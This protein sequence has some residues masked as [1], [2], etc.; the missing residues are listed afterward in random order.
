[1]P[2]SRTVRSEVLDFEPYSPG[3][4]IPEI[5]K[6]HNLARVIKLA[7]NENPLGTSPLVQR[8]IERL[9]GYAFR[10]PSPGC[11]ELTEALAEHLQIPGDRFV[12]GNGSDELID[13]LLRIKA[14]PGR[15]NIVVFRPCFSIYRLQARLCGL[16]VR[17]VPLREDFS[18]PWAEALQQVDEN[19]AFFFVTNPDNPSGF[20]APKSQILDIAA[21]L[22]ENTLLVLDEAY[23]DFAHDQNFHSPLGK[24]S[25]LDN[26]VFL[27]TFSKIY[28]LAGM[29]LGYGIMPSWLAEFLL[30]V[31]LPFSVN[32]LA[33]QAGLAALRDRH[34]YDRTLQTVIRGREF[35][36]GEME[37]LGCR[38]FPSQAN[39]LMFRP[40]A[41]AETIF[42]ALLAKGVIVR[43]L[44]SY[45]LDEYLRVSVGHD[46]E[47]QIFVQ[48][49]QE[50]LADHA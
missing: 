11:P 2:E 13:L 35:L 30:R 31:K 22:P 21:R 23:I 43:P 46:E 28:G 20:A 12:V 34:F 9:A 17:E 19:T 24:W 49:L 7:S 33:E 26:V 8:L 3:L 5:K 40:P 16:E 1:M 39:F 36:N 47:N 32:V 50:A 38:V 41:D 37:R 10:Y 29:R 42:E 6:R 18:F 44:G 4:S 45:G 48:A 25:E 14:E 27:R 15:D